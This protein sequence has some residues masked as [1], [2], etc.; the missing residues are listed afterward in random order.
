MTKINKNVIYDMK[1]NIRK[2]L[3]ICSN[4]LINSIEGIQKYLLNSIEGLQLE[5]IVITDQT[6][7]IINNFEVDIE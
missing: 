7:V 4:R 6:G 5:N 1:R 2:Y 3:R